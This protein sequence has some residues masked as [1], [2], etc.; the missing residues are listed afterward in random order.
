MFCFCSSK[1]CVSRNFLI[2]CVVK[3]L[4]ILFQKQREIQ[5]A[6]EDSSVE[7]KCNLKERRPAPSCSI[8][9]RIFFHFPHPRALNVCSSNLQSATLAGKQPS[10][11]ASKQQI[12]GR[13][14]P[15]V[16]HPCKKIRYQYLFQNY[17][18]FLLP[19]PPWTLPSRARSP[20]A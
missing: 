1:D 9:R 11:H 2:E 10:R 16:R 17:S 19:C 20:I 12:G 4:R 13:M 7:S 14:L 3:N 5:R 6:A 18:L 8:Q 15:F